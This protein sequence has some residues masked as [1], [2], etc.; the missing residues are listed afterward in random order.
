MYK[1][2]LYEPFL[3]DFILTKDD[4]IYSRDYSSY[5]AF[6]ID[7]T[8]SLYSTTGTILTTGVTLNNIL[9]T[10]YDNGLLNN[11]SI[12]EYYNYVKVNSPSSYTF[13]G[14]SYLMDFDSLITFNSNKTLLFEGD[15]PIAI[16]PTD[17][18]FLYIENNATFNCM[19]LSTYVDGLNGSYN[20]Q[21]NLG[22]VTGTSL[23]YDRFSFYLISNYV[24]IQKNGTTIAQFNVSGGTG[25][26][27]YNSAAGVFSINTTP[28]TIKNLRLYNQRNYI[29]GTTFDITNSESI[30]NP[31]LTGV[32]FNV[33]GITYDV[34]RVPFKLLPISGYTN[35]YNYDI[36]NQT[37]INSTQIYNKLNGGFYQGF[38]KLFNYPVEFFQTRVNKGW[39]VNMLITNPPSLEPSGNTLNTLHPQNS[40]FIFYLGTR[41]ENKYYIVT[42]SAINQL[43]NILNLPPSGDTQ[44]KNIIDYSIVPSG[45]T[46]SGF[47]PFIFDPNTWYYAYPYY[48]FYPEDF[49]YGDFYGETD[50]YN[51]TCTPSGTTWSSAEPISVINSDIDYGLTNEDNLY[52]VDPI[53]TI[54]GTPYSGWYCIHNGLYF[55]GRTFNQYSHHNNRRGLLKKADLYKYNDIMNNAFGIFID[56]NGCVGYKNVYKTDP[57]FTGT[58][59]NPVS[60][61][62]N[63]TG[64]TNDSFVDITTEC[65]VNNIN[66]IRTQY[67]TIRKVTG[68]NPIISIDDDIT[69]F[70]YITVVFERDFSYDTDCMLE[71][72]KYKNGTLKIYINGKLVFEDN[73]FTEVI[74]HELDTNS[75]YQEGV[76]FNLS[77]GGG[78]QGLLDNMNILGDFTSPPDKLIIDEFFSG[79]YIGG[80]KSI[81]MYLTP[82]DITEII[83][84]VNIIKNTYD[85]YTLQGGRYVLLKNLY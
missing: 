27:Y 79:T 30:V 53:F 7:V 9:L 1:S 84:E 56:S 80:V 39:T 11:N 85:L 26:N 31:P 33:S 38:F 6:S 78:S 60:P 13:T 69:R 40:G 68:K 58:S 82:L 10:G 49:F 63:P 55:T 21:T 35:S 74:P 22:N 45:I 47:T 48:D 57:C 8:Q 71:Y 28:Y 20:I 46:T 61:L 29:S 59:Q 19:L 72:G 81:Q 14:T 70:L 43:K 12:A 83:N 4:V 67:F 36:I 77:F 2:V 64:I 76:P 15:L 5:E 66:E 18:P 41:A 62:Q 37:M 75:F 73:N 17:T 32:T 51:D 65:D 16:N 52:T 54:S 42:G 23:N 3:G 44:P 50:F 25:Y 24:Y 34:G